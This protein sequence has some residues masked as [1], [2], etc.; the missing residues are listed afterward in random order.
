MKTTVL[1][2]TIN[3]MF[4]DRARALDRL[5][6]AVRAVDMPLS[7]TRNILKGSYKDEKGGILSWHLVSY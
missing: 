3:S 6:V 4:P 1:K 7:K 2:K 5:D